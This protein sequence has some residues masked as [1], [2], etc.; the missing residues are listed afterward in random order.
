[1]T[2]P[3]QPTQPVSLDKGAWGAPAPWP[4]APPAAPP[5]AWPPAPQGYGEP[6]T[7]W[8]PVPAQ[9]PEVVPSY[10]LAD[11]WLRLGASLINGVLMIVTLFVGY[12]V[13]AL[14]LWN[15]G[16]NPGKKMLGLAVVK[17]D[18]GRLCTFG[19]MAVRN[20]VF[21]TLVLQ[22]A[23]FFTLGLAWLVDALMIFGDRRQR[24]I[25]KM[26]GTLVVVTRR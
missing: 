17:A 11:P 5:V 1:M 18:T 6:H 23:S 21:G 12:L 20:V 15:E 7:A 8:G 16:T 2:D 19:D 24:G 22:T 4:P 26:S 9:R 25:D 3:S 14:V 13:W 10:A